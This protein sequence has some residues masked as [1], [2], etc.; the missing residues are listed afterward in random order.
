M[1]AFKGSTTIPL[2]NVISKPALVLKMFLTGF[3][4]KST[5]IE[6]KSL[7]PFIAIW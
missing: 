6:N 3:A 5:E 2:K 4:E 1:V 7:D